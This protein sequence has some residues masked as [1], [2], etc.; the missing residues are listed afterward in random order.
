[1]LLTNLKMIFK[2]DYSRTLRVGELYE[3]QIYSRVEDNE[4]DQPRW[5]NELMIVP[6]DE[7][8]S[9][10]PRRDNWRRRN[11][12]PILIL[13]AT[14]LNTGHNWQFTASYM[15][16]PPSAIMTEVDGNYRLRRMYYNDAPKKHR[17]IRLGHAVAASSCVPGLFE[18]LV[19]EGLYKDKIV[20][21]VDGGVHD[22]QGTASLLE[23]GCQVL[24][25]SDASG[26]MSSDDSPS[27]KLL[28]VLVRSDS[29]SQERVRHAQYR[30]LE[31]RRRSSQIQGLMFVHLKKDL[32][33]DPVDWIDCPDPYDASADARPAELR[34]PVTRY[35][36]RKDIQQR[37]AAVRTDLDSFTDGEAYALMA[38]G[39]FMT[40]YELARS[41]TAFG[42]FESEQ[43]NR[44][45]A[46]RFLDFENPIKQPGHSERLLELLTV[47]GN[48]GFKI[49][50]LSRPLRTI[51]SFTVTLVM[52]GIA[53]LLLWYLKHPGSWERLWQQSL[54]SVSFGDAYGPYTLR[55][56]WLG[57]ILLA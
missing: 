6:N 16:E 2:S 54:V 22:N 3:K 51:T 33:V 27:N 43:L 9:F 29:I 42:R 21:L 30:E 11:K 53:W 13:N 18:P 7:A 37:L 1:E 24:L 46:W 39:Y 47:A 32:N 55:A 14:S 28:N 20:R 5:L 44:R 23:E 49:W 10:V 4:G 26:Q 34:G 15:G 45:S 50:Q 40:E 52:A 12:V 19:L 41:V 48:L 31:M 8:E 57:S 17:R 56:G 35:G 25:V 38:S 36:V